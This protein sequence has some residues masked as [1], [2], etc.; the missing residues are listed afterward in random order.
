MIGNIRPGFIRAN[1]YSVTMSFS[2]FTS[3]T[4]VTNFGAFVT[5]IFRNVDGK[6]INRGKFDNPTKSI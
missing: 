2:K 5:K 4:D 1:C 6:V 3:Q